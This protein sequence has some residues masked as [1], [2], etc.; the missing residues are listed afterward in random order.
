MCVDADNTNPYTWAQTL[1]I[2]VQP[3]VHLQETRRL[4]GWEADN[5]AY[6]LFIMRS[7]RIIFFI[8]GWLY[9]KH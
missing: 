5:L 8:V 7:W 2:C 4:S 1:C 6:L 9:A 3:C